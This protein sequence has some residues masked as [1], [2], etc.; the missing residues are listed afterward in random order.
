L[1]RPEGPDEEEARHHDGCQRHD[2]DGLQGECEG[3]DEFLDG[4]GDD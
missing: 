1:Q 2:R 4:E 3:V